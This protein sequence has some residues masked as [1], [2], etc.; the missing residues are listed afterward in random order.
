MSI[1]ISLYRFVILA[2]DGV[3]DLLTDKQ[4]I[5]IYRYIYRYRYRYR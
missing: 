4:R 3:W 1:Y 5:S 2:C